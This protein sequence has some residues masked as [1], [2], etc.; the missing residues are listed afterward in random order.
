MLKLRLDF[1][2][3][4]SKD[5]QR[6]E[7]NEDSFAID[8]S[9]GRVAI[10]DG[11]S[12]SY[13]SRR[14]AKILVDAFVVEPIVTRE[15]LNE[16]TSRYAL[17]ANFDALTWSAQAAFERG[18]FSTLLGMEIFSKGDTVGVVAV[19]DSIAV[20]GRDREILTSHPFTSATEFSR[21]PTLLC[22]LDINN[23]FFNNTFI[24]NSWVTWRVRPGDRLYM[25]TDAVGE[26]FLKS[27]SACKMIELN[28]IT[29][30]DDFV[31]LISWLRKVR[32]IRIDDSTIIRL[33]VQRGEEDASS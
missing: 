13:D 5:L 7:L 33:S 1:A 27:A 28:S 32:G 31:D 22:T 20:L 6:P 4:L 15:W 17:S 25:M 3:S 14:W 9:A 19:G 18:S 12:E 21:R 10:A 2:A 26:W 29:T 11:A 30:V 16:L 24:S 8:V 23:D